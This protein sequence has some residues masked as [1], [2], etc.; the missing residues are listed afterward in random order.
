MIALEWSKTQCSQG[1]DEENDR[2]DGYSAPECTDHCYEMLM[3]LLVRLMH[4]PE[5]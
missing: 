4:Q 2:G 1:E 5:V 3:Y